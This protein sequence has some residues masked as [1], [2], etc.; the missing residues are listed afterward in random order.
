MIENGKDAGWDMPPYKTHAVWVFGKDQYLATKTLC[1]SA[2]VGAGRHYNLKSLYGLFESIVTE[3][4][5]H[6]AT[7]KRGIVV[8]RSSS[9]ETPP[10]KTLLSLK[11]SLSRRL[12]I[13]LPN[14]SG[15]AA[16]AVPVF[17]SNPT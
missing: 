4:A 14:K 16:R 17:F 5:Q 15:A 9:Y 2:V 7:G 12:E 6:K 11:L 1:M 10:K 13:E 8:S 3:K